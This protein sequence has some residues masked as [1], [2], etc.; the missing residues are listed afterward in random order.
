MSADDTIL[1]IRTLNPNMRK[2]GCKYRYRVLH[3]QAAENFSEAD[4]I[5]QYNGY[6]KLFYTRN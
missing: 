1:I 6:T 5:R 4:Q 2:D 3:V